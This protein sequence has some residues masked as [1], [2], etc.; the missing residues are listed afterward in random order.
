[1]RD[2][3]LGR[4]IVRAADLELVDAERDLV[5][6]RDDLDLDVDRVV[7]EVQ[8]E[9]PGVGLHGVAVEALVVDDHP[10]GLHDLVLVLDQDVGLVLRGQA[11]VVE[12]PNAEL[13][14][15][16]PERVLHQRGAVTE[17]AQPEV[18]LVAAQA[19]FA[20][21]R[22]HEAQQTNHHRHER[23]CVEARDQGTTHF[24]PLCAPRALLCAD[25]QRTIQALIRHETFP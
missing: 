12:Q 24:S 3:A 7:P 6:V 23:L 21:A 16:E 25:F 22:Q 17:L 5:A 1:M 8:E 4:V 11:A 14:V 19:R 10:L 15:L 20:A 9:L 2:L 13:V 18:L